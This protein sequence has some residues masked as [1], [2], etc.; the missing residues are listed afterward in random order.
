MRTL[1]DL[2][3]TSLSPTNNY[4]KPL[5]NLLAYKIGNNIK[6][7]NSLVTMAHLTH[8]IKFQTAFMAPLKALFEINDTYYDINFSSF[9]INTAV[10]HLETIKSIKSIISIISEFFNLKNLFQTKLSFSLPMKLIKNPFLFSDSRTYRN[11][12]SVPNDLYVKPLTSQADY[13]QAQLL[14]TASPT[15][16][17]LY[18]NSNILINI[19]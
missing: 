4:Y 1:I 12:F 5:Y 13:Y 7:N 2:D 14:L 17:S 18:S 10:A 16:S 11:F 8:T 19:Y 9:K 6:S 3:L 15:V